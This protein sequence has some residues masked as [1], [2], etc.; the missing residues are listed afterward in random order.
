[1]TMTQESPASA[2]TAPSA[3][4]VRKSRVLTMTPGK[5]TIVG[6]Q[7]I[8]VTVFTVTDGTF[9]WD[10]Y[11]TATDEWWEGCGACDG[12]SG[13]KRHF[14]HVLGG[15]CFQCGGS[16]VSRMAGTEAGMTRRIRARISSRTS[17]AN[18]VQRAAQRTLDDLE[19]WNVAHPNLASD[20]AR[21]RAY[22]TLGGY[23][24]GDI[25]LFATRKALSVRQEEFAIS[26]LVQ[27]AYDEAADVENPPLPNVHV[28]AEGE[29]V[30]LTGVV[31]VAHH[32]PAERFD[33]SAQMLIVLE[34]TLAEGVA[35]VRTYTSARWAF[36]V[37]KGATITI[38]AT[39]ASHD[40][41]RYGPQTSVKRPTRVS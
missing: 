27:R 6:K 14:A 26:M 36:D 11:R 22:D 33:R 3:N 15:V 7:R 4:G 37:E 24:L 35:N 38:K 12:D 21:V 41:G 9:S 10:L 2:A 31:S 8:H 16:G 32:C 25:A 28:G 18:A 40:E 20:L 39:V 29:K 13:Y 23:A 1:M 19:A 34:C 5:K 30:T 17:R